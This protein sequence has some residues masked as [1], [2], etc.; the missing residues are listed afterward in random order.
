M[1]KESKILTDIHNIQGHNLE[2]ISGNFL[3]TIDSFLLY[4]YE[5]ILEYKLDSELLI[6]LLQMD[7][8][9]LEKQKWHLAQYLAVVLHWVDVQNY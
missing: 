5:Q 9:P 3:D 8:C 7:Y 1:I 4:F 2:D 6:V